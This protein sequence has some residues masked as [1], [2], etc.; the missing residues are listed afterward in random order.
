[1]SKRKAITR[2]EL[3]DDET[4]TVLADALAGRRVARQIASALRRVNGGSTT[5]RGQ[6]GRGV[7]RLVEMDQ[8]DGQLSRPRRR[9]QSS[10]TS[11][12]AT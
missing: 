7:A 6:A 1:M 5:R 12:P 10:A 11:E 8:L 3:A 2:A 4:A 9:F